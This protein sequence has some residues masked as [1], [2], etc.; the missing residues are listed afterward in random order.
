M[1]Y[2]LVIILFLIVTMIVFFFLKELDNIKKHI[3]EKTEDISASINNC[4]RIMQ[5]EF[6]SCV[7]KIKILNG[8]YVEQVRKMNDYGSQ[9]ITNMSSYHY[10]DSE[11]KTDTK[12]VKNASI[13]YLSDTREKIK[14]QQETDNNFKISY[15]N[16][17]VETDKMVNNLVNH[18]NDAEKKTDSSKSQKKPE[19]VL[20]EDADSNDITDFISESDSHTDDISEST[21]DDSTDNK[22]SVNESDT[23]DESISIE[24]NKDLINDIKAKQEEHKT[25]QK[26]DEKS[27]NSS[28]YGSITLGSLKNKGVKTI[29]KIEIGNNDNDSIKTNDI[30]QLSLNTLK[31]VGNYNIEYLKKMAKIFSIPMTCKEGTTRRP[32]RKDELYDKI[33]LHLTESENKN[34]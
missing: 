5:A 27:N 1:D 14:N 28:K 3:T 7:K 30:E 8:E 23:I 29:N 22:S 31:P 20:I 32:L 26:E 33:K 24:I 18:V 21:N 15:D 12:K 11:P 13:P 19:L 10:T 25:E 16:P 34:N 9:P 2:K 6:T 17:H 4:T